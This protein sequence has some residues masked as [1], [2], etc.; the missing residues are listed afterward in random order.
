VSILKRQYNKK[1]AVFGAD[2][3]K[4]ANFDIYE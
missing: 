1:E 3:D 4:K 2:L